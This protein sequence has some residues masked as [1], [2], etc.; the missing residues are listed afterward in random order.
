MGKVWVLDSETKGTGAQMVPLEKVQTGT[1]P[2]SR[3][4]RPPLPPRRTRETPE[5]AR[6]NRFKL[7][8]VMT[9][10]PLLEDADARA[11]VERLR[12]VRSLVDVTVHAWDERAG[13]WQRLSRGEERA[14]WRLR[15]R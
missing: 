4:R 12:D 11:T 13:R 8:D 6:P 2:R 1:A 7:M 5:P 15:D 14:L 9:G 3:R 10:Q